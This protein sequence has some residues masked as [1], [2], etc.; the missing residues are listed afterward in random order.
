MDIT[1][2]DKINHYVGIDISKLKLDCWLRPSEE[3]LCCE[4]EQEGFA[5]LSQWLTNQGC[6]REDTIICL[7][8]TG[9]YGKR[10]LLDL[11]KADWSCTV[12]KTT[13]TEKVRPEHHRKDDAFDASLIA[14][15]A[16]RF[17]D[18]LHPSEP[19]EEAL[20]RMSQLYIERRRLVR[21]RAS[22]KTKRTQAK[23]Q[24]HCPT[25]IKEGWGEQL[26][27]LTNQIDRLED[28]I[29]E[30]V[31]NHA[32][33]SG[34]FD[35]LVS[36]PG[37]AEVT[38]WMWLI[39]FYGETKLNPKEIAS[40]FGVAPHGKKSGSSVRGKTRS[41]G[42][43]ASEMRSN[44]TMAARSAA[45]HYEKFSTYKQKKLDEDKPKPV[46]R[47]NLVNKLITIICAIWNTGTYYDPDH[48]S[49]FDREKKAG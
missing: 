7:E 36:I 4:N 33:L 37:I 17:T 8:D 32:G 48:T 30:I 10:L 6:R 18:R 27:L 20:E 31:S 49:R 16:D 19:P 22:T 23:Q 1:K 44:M 14:E 11:R 25:I 40:R 38:A 39:L 42:H 9:I 34:Y 24:P 35:L 12:E 15:Y 13:I 43:G 28:G 29:H 3:Y 47:N 26:K 41:S 5:R 2:I 21:Q 45:T 46:V